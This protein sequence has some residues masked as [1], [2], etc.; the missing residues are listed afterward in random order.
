M[1][2]NCSLAAVD[3]ENRQDL[4]SKRLNHI[5]IRGQPISTNF[6]LP[7]GNQQK[8]FEVSMK[9]IFMRSSNENLKE[10]ADKVRLFLSLKI[11]SSKIEFIFC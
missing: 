6:E 10:M 4:F 9:H 1:R 7:F 2:G 3:P 11:L 5:A 8:T